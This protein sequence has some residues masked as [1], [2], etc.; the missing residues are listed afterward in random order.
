MRKG[1]PLP[2]N[3]DAANSLQSVKNGNPAERFNF[4]DTGKEDVDAH[5]YW[6][7]EDAGAVNEERASVVYL[8]MRIAAVAMHTPPGKREHVLRKVTLLTLQGEH[9]AKEFVPVTNG[10]NEAIAPHT[11]I[12]ELGKM[13]I[14]LL[15]DY[16]APTDRVAIHVSLGPMRVDRLRRTVASA[17]TI[18]EEMA[19]AGGNESLIDSRE[20]VRTSM[21]QAS[22]G[23]WDGFDLDAAL[24]PL[25]AAS[26]V[27]ANAPTNGQTA[28]L[29]G[30]D[31]T[32]VSGVGLNPTTSWHPV[33]R[34]NAHS[35]PAWSGVGYADGTTSNE[36]RLSYSLATPHMVEGWATLGVYSPE[37]AHRAAEALHVAAVAAALQRL[38]LEFGAEA[39]GNADENRDESD[40]LLRAVLID[41]KARPEA[42]APAALKVTKH[43]VGHS[44]LANVL[45]RATESAEEWE[46]VVQRI[47]DTLG[48]LAAIHGVLGS[49]HWLMSTATMA[50]SIYTSDGGK[51]HAGMRAIYDLVSVNAT[52]AFANMVVNR[53]YNWADRGEPQRLWWNGRRGGARMGAGGAINPAGQ[54]LG[55]LAGGVLKNGATVL[56]PMA[57]TGYSVMHYAH[58]FAA[59]FVQREI[60]SDHVLGYVSNAQHSNAGL[61]QGTGSVRR[62]TASALKAIAAAAMIQATHWVIDPFTSKYFGFDPPQPDVMR[63]GVDATSWSMPR[64]NS[65][66]DVDELSKVVEWLAANRL[67][68]KFGGESLSE[69]T[70]AIIAQVQG[71]I[72]DLQTKQKVASPM[73][74][75]AKLDALSGEAYAKAWGERIAENLKS[76]QAEVASTACVNLA[77]LASLDMRLGGKAG[78][79]GADRGRV[80]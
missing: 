14:K 9:D 66:A 62:V 67:E 5:S 48:R 25:T 37:S 35:G 26:A 34:R 10:R 29:N 57:A 41:G 56:L 72:V 75:D 23:N 17:V 55:G 28:P 43:V 33:A 77:W 7:Y 38:Q 50:A 42:V 70:P 52:G 80:F 40:R 63:E 61:P 36:K 24:A 21:L 12:D 51:G 74:S 54:F 58:T 79:D 64:L 44:Q 71:M 30:R 47:A 39:G 65:V 49:E 78:R 11:R 1:E 13:L 73:P 53:V 18:P 31:V 2:A 68:H 8:A 27:R 22:V 16:T 3:D 19:T 20:R 45:T 46:P 32:R 4:L 15:V 76:S 6:V 69:G 60:E 59:E